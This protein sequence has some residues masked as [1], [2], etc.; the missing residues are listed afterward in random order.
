MDCLE[1]FQQTTGDARGWNPGLSLAEQTQRVRSEHRGA[2]A[3]DRKLAADVGHV[4]LH[5]QG[6]DEKLIGDFRIREALREAGEHLFFPR[7]ERFGQ[8]AGRTGGRGQALMRRGRDTLDRGY[9]GR[10]VTRMVRL[11]AS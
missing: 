4:A 9:D 1:P 7:G 6:R 8:C 5:R 2:P 3:G 10:G 11:L